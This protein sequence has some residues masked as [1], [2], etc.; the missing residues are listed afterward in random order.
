MGATWVYP[1]LHKGALSPRLARDRGVARCRV[2][3]PRNECGISREAEEVKRDSSALLEQI[4]MGRGEA[5]EW[6]FPVH[7]QEI[8][9]I[10]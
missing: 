2:N 10:G 4:R 7:T 1:V 9:M 3:K 6:E 8:G 5:R